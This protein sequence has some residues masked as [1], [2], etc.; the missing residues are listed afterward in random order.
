M[1][2]ISQTT[3]Q[4][5]KQGNRA[6]LSPD[7]IQL[8]SLITSH[9]NE[10]NQ[11]VH[12][13]VAQN[14]ALEIFRNPDFADDIKA[15]DDQTDQFWNQDFDKPYDENES[16]EAANSKKQFAWEGIDVALGLEQSALEYAGDNPKSLSSIYSNIDIYRNTGTLPVDA[17]KKFQD[18][19]QILEKSI[20]DKSL[21]NESP[22]F[23]VYE[24][25]GKVHAVL[26][27]TVA[28]S[29][30]YRKGFGKYS[31]KAKQFID[32]VIDRTVSLSNFAVEILEKL[33][34]DYFRHADFKN[35]LLNLIPVP[36]ETISELKIEKF[37]LKTR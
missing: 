1:P 30:I 21:P 7:F 25:S 24:D 11:I 15:D 33:Q 2:N 9:N 35:A 4:N 36:T 17:D 27:P 23:E 16:G 5:Q 31:Y 37:S 28:D 34:G 29:L 13:E 6:V 8:K 3:S 19:L 12:K 22:T 10:I 14:P 32:R 20:F 18:D 26:I